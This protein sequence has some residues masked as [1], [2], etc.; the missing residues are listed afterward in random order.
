MPRPTALDPL[1]RSLHS[2]KGVGPQLGALLKRFFGGPDGR[3]AIA[4]D[5]LMHMPSGIVDRRRMEGVAGTYVG[6]VATLKLHID[7]HLPPPRA[8]PHLPHRVFAH[9]E[10]GEIQLVFFRSKGGWVE[11][12]L[13]VGEERYV[14]GTI[15]FFQGEKQ[16]THPDHIVDVQSFAD[17]PLV[18][19][20][21]PLTH[22]LN[23]KALSRMVRQTLET[24]PELPEWVPEARLG[25]FKWPSFRAAMAAVHA[26]RAP[27]EA[28]LWAPARTRLA[29]DEYLAGQLALMIV[30]SQLVAAR[31][32]A[33]RFTGEVTARVEAALPFQLTAGQR[34][35]LADIRNDLASPD[36]MSRLLQGDVGSGKTVV[37]AAAALVATSAG[38]QAAVMAPTE[39][40]AEQHARTLA[41]FLEPLEIEVSWADGV[42]TVRA[43]FVDDTVVIDRASGMHLNDAVSTVTSE[44]R[45]V[46]TSGAW[47][48]SEVHLASKT[49]GVQPCA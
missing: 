37:A 45:V 32:V 17:M 38:F 42:A 48:V 33:R 34:A 19:P 47:K 46:S 14:S 13:P 39:L 26:P 12:A 40:L 4:L 1:F 27:D 2:I 11:R 20:V 22:G 25:H 28:E 9:D 7:R 24:L 6:H 36:R 3:D 30:R 41:R 31:G 21:Y 49:Q 44:L 23:S 43:C 10:T 16:I 15:G 5:L 29:Y 8:K 35:A 18:E